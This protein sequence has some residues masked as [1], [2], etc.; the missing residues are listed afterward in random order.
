MET[1]NDISEGPQT[2][3]SI[4][5]IFWLVAVSMLLVIGTYSSI[6]LVLEE[7]KNSQH[8][9]GFRYYTI[10]SPSGAMTFNCTDYGEYYDS[11][12]NALKAA[13][14]HIHTIKTM[15]ADSNLLII[16]GPFTFQTVK[17]HD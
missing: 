12:D 7:R 8:A 10:S 15:V 9:W 4:Q 5:D 13:T 17:P 1:A 16:G 14:K 6:I 11:Q 3:L 2:K